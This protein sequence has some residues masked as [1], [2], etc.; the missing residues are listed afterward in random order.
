MP[1]E[2]PK[3]KSHC[4]KCDK[5]LTVKIIDYIMKKV[6]YQTDEGLLCADCFWEKEAE[7]D[8]EIEKLKQ[9]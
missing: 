6:Q 2:K 5:R 7:R 9:K 8:K 4:V 3:R 1:I